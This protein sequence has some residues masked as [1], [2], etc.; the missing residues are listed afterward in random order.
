MENNEKLTSTQISEIG[1]LDDWRILLRSLQASFSTGSMTKGVDFAARISAAA[2]EANHHPDL[3]ITYERVHALLTTHSAY[4]LTTRDVELAR[5]ISAIAGELGV[6][7]DPNASLMAGVGLVNVVTN[8]PLMSNRW[9][10][11]ASVAP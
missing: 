3:T 5:A 4:G 9:A 2:E 10:T 8:A 1:G 11:P 7:A 6:R